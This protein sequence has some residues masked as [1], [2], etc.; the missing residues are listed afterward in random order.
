M[1]LKGVNK[2]VII[3]KNPGSEI[4][5]EAYFIVKS[6]SVKGIMKQSKE[7][8]MVIEANR[9]ISDYHN[10]QRSIIEKNGI[11]SSIGGDISELDNFLNAKKENFI[12]F[13]NIDKTN[14]KTDKINNIEKPEKNKKENKFNDIN[15][16]EI[17]QSIADLTDD[18]IFEDE[19]IFENMQNSAN[20][21]DDFYRSP[22]FIRY[23]E[24]EK[25][26]KFPFDFISSKKIRNKNIKIPPKSFFIGVGFMSAIIILIRLVEYILL[27]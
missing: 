11:A 25:L 24:D 16:I 7:N 18:E 14:K 15:N 3:I 27:R 12:N 5:E 9:I 20:K 22:D 4:F 17:N 8:E 6:G 21:Y 19:K 2:R 26:Y 13:N 23:G 1:L 10:Q